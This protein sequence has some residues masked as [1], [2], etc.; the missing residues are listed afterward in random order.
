MLILS[1]SDEGEK[2]ATP[3]PSRPSL[4]PVPTKYAKVELEFHLL[5]LLYKLVTLP[6][7]PLLINLKVTVLVFFVFH[8]QFK[9][10][11]LVLLVDL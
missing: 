2:S 8:L 10:V 4:S 3:K 6:L 9:Q 5:P 7:L 1:D 11:T